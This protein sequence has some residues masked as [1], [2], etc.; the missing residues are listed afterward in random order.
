VGE[1]SILSKLLENRNLCFDSVPLPNCHHGVRRYLNST[2]LENPADFLLS[3]TRIL[4]EQIQDSVFNI[5]RD[6]ILKILPAAKFWGQSF[7]SAS[8]I[9][10]L[11]WEYV[12]RLTPMYLQTAENLYMAKKQCQFELN[13][14]L[15]GYKERKDEKRRKRKRAFKPKNLSL[16]AQNLIKMASPRGRYIY[17]RCSMNANLSY[18]SWKLYA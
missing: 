10:V 4:P 14:K 11:I 15:G 7:N 1:C 3:K 6:P 18:N 12:L 2:L 13:I 16:N 9:P 17:H 5:I 8:L